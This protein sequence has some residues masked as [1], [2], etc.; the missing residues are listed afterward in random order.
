MIENIVFWNPWWNDETIKNF[1]FRKTYETILPLFER[2]ETLFFTGVRRS[3]KTTI[4]YFLIKKL[5][6]TVAKENILYLNLDDALFKDKT[7]DEIYSEYLNFFPD[8][9]GKIYIFLDE[10]QNIDGWERWIKK[11]YDSQ[12]NIKFIVTGSKSN[13]LKKHS[14]LLTGRMIEFQIF[15]LSFT[16]FLDFNNFKLDKIK[17][18]SKKP[19]LLKYYNDYLKYGGFPEV[20][21]EKDEKLKTLLLKE[22]YGNIKNK[23]II[24]YFNIRES[25]KFDNLSLFI[26]SNISKPFSSSKIGNAINLSTSIV[27]NYLNYSELMYFFLSLN[28]FNYSFKTQITKPRKIYSID[29][30]LIN[31]V[32]FK[33]SENKGRLLENLV[34]MELKRQGNEIYYHKNKFECDFLIKEGLKI[35]K[36]IQVCYELNNE[37]KEREIKGLVEAMQTHKLKEGLIL[38]FDDEDEIILNNKKISIKP[39][40][41]WLLDQ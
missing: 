13:L 41:K 39:V 34:F 17:I 22:Y 28:H 31:A 20:V 16:E 7:L 21:L 38:T 25:K 33:F 37:D 26:I 15:P 12:E 8:L 1:N 36:A 35:T 4:M 14:S 2:K 18:I 9:N 11:M 10:I 27:E 32:S 29:T 3:G 24:T 30:G 6:K 19:M 23:D 40:W 5:L